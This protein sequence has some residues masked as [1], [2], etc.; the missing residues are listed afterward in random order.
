MADS[1]LQQRLEKG[2]ILGGLGGDPDDDWDRGRPSAKK[3][4]NPFI[5]PK[6]GKSRFVFRRDA[7]LVG[8]PPVEAKKTEELASVSELGEE[9]REKLLEKTRELADSAKKELWDILSLRMAA[10]S[11]KGDVSDE[12]RTLLLEAMPSHDVEKFLRSGKLPLFSVIDKA[13]YARV[14]LW[15]AKHAGL[16][17]SD[18]V[19]LLLESKFGKENRDDFGGGHTAGDGGHAVGAPARTSEK[20]PR[21]QVAGEGGNSGLG[22][23][24]GLGR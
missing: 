4:S 24:T 14:V 3:L 9:E 20:R 11:A 1:S 10:E 8:G 22:V 12:A 18:F 17:D 6:K 7:S 21:Q 19:E 16:L 15:V 23:S 2:G 5:L 13:V